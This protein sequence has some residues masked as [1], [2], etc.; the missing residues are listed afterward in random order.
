MYRM[1][2][3]KINV[4]LFNVYKRYKDMATKPSSEL[5]RVKEAVNAHNSTKHIC[6]GIMIGILV[7]MIIY[8]IVMFSMY[9]SGSWIFAPYIPPTPQKPHYYPLGSVKPMTQEEINH[10]NEII[11]ASIAN[12][13]P[14]NN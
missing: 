4:S 3:N 9:V 12:N 8:I 6:I 11:T 2:I 13:P 7:V 5:A 10:R 14:G 1:Y